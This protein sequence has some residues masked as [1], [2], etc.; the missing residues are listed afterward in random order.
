[1]VNTPAMP[2][3]RNR[4]RL[5]VVEDEIRE[6]LLQADTGR[7]GSFRRTLYEVADTLRDYSNCFRWEREEFDSLTRHVQLGPFWNLLFALFLHSLFVGDEFHRRTDARRRLEAELESEI[8]PVRRL[9]LKRKLDQHIPPIERTPISAV[10]LERM[11]RLV[12]AGSTN[13]RKR[14]ERTPKLEIGPWHEPM[15]SEDYGLRLGLSRSG[16]KD[17]FNSI[18]PR[19]KA[20]RAGRVKARYPAATNWRVLLQFLLMTKRSPEWKRDFCISLLDYYQRNDCY[21]PESKSQIRKILRK[22]KIAPIPPEQRAATFDHFFPPAPAPVTDP[23]DWLLL[24]KS[25]S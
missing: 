1:M 20:L 19:V 12:K 24:G 13:R 11:D 22:I 7:S 5:L 6:A 17:L 4:K 25:E 2:N 3:G 14:S 15:T 23:F 10:E 9:E 18:R 21:T 16:V 8:N